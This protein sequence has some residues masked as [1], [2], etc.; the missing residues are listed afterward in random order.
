MDASWGQQ[1]AY[2]TMSQQ[3]GQPT[4][5]QALL[6]QHHRVAAQ[7]AAQQQSQRQTMAALSTQSA[8]WG[9]PQQHTSAQMANSFKDN[10]LG[11]CRRPV[12]L[13]LELCKHHKPQPCMHSWPSKVPCRITCLCNQH[14]LQ[15]NSF[16]LKRLMSQRPHR[17]PTPSLTFLLSN[18]NIQPQHSTYHL[19]PAT[20]KATPPLKRFPL[21]T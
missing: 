5:A 18:N 3:Q 10:S 2:P 15:D 7:Q 1:T 9:M 17:Q 8:G 6:A 16:F 14:S 19:Q 12:T 4:Q 21:R 20:H 11:A 13:C